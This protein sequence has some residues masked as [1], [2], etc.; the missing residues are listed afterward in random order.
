VV[1]GTSVKSAVAQVVPVPCT[2]AVVDDKPTAVRSAVTEVMVPLRAATVQ[3]SVVVPI[4]VTGFGE[5]VQAVTAGLP[6]VTVSVVAIVVGAVPS[7]A[8]TVSGVYVNNNLEVAIVMPVRF[9]VVVVPCCVRASVVVPPMVDRSTLTDARLQSISEAVQVRVV[10]ATPSECMAVG[11][12]A[13][14]VNTGAVFAGAVVVIAGA[15]VGVPTAAAESVAVTVTLELVTGAVQRGT[16]IPVIDHVHEAVVQPDAFVSGARAEPPIA[17][18]SAVTVFILLLLSATVQVSAVAVVPFAGIEV[19]EKAQ[20]VTTGAAF[21]TVRDAMPVPVSNAVK[22][23]FAVTVTV[24]AF[25]RIPVV[26]GTSVRSAVA[27][28][29]PVPCTSAV[30][31]DKPTAVRSAVAEAMVPLRAVI[32]QV[33]VVV[34]I[35]V[36]GVGENEQAVT[37]GLPAVTVSVVAI[38]VGA[39]PSV[40][41]TVSG[42]YVSNNLEVAIVMPVRFHVVVVP[43]WVRASVVVPP[44]VDRSTLTDAR[45]QSISEAVQVRVVVVVPFEWMDVG[46][47]A[48]PVKTGA[49]FA[50]AVV[51]IV[52]A[53]VG[54]P[55]AAEASFAVTVTL[56]AVTGVV[57]CGTV[58]PVFEYVHAVLTQVPFVRGVRAMPPIAVRSAVTVVT[59]RLS[60]VTVQVSAVA[61][62]PFAGIEVGENA[63][64]VTVGVTFDTVR[65]ALPVPVK[66]VASV[67]LTITEYAFGRMPVVPGTSVIPVFVQVPVESVRAVVA[68]KPKADRSAVTVERSASASVTDVQVSTVVPVGVTV[69][70]ANVQ[71]ETTG[72]TLASAVFVEPVKSAPEIANVRTAAQKNFTLIVFPP[73]RLLF[74]VFLKTYLV[75]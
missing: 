26:P 62:V 8:V 2:S 53:V 46:E 35:G 57:Q 18:R 60:S 54:V 48:Q 43:C 61:V 15:V 7:V 14:P 4:G 65:D 74:Y 31:D 23:S 11:E 42:V 63:Q 58:I 38:V 30:V 32:V 6:A 28:V 64:A 34:P 36:T 71:P 10:V 37:V 40:A 50:G 70:G 45:L 49:V 33:S 66:L 72:A 20:A 16:V 27:H 25:G 73:D 17:V 5:N 52:G 75:G 12:N 3:V 67:A 47:N 24:Y 55:V 44:M 1:P 39:V 22:L 56:E 69:L 29:F 51:V 13:Q 9:H 68:D 21:D 41:V 59:F 19:G